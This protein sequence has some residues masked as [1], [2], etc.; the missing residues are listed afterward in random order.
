MGYRT[1]SQN[2]TSTKTTESTAL[3]VLANTGGNGYIISGANTSLAG[4]GL[5][6][7]T[8][9]VNTP[10]TLIPIA[11]GGLVSSPVITNIQFLSSAGSILAATNAASTLGGNILI[12]GTNFV[13]NVQVWVNNTTPATTT[14]ISSTQL[15]ATLPANA[16]GIASIIVASAPTPPAVTANIQFYPAPIW[17]NSNVNLYF[18][19]NNTVSNIPL[20]V[21]TLTGDTISFANTVLPTGLTVQPNVTNFGNGTYQSYI[22]GT[23][24]GYPSGYSNVSF[25][26]TAINSRLESTTQQFTSNIS[27]PIPV[28]SSANTFTFTQNGTAITTRITASISDCVPLT[29]TVTKGFLPTG[30]SLNTAGYITGTITCYVGGYNCVPFSITASDVE[31]QSTTQTYKANVSVGYTNINY[32]IVGGGGAGGGWASPGPQQGGSG[33]GGGG[34]A[35][36]TTSVSIGCSFTVSVGG[37]GATSPSAGCGSGGSGSSVFGASAGGGGGGGYETAASSGYPTSFG[38]C[39]SMTLGM[40]GGGG[41]GG[42]GTKGT[43]GRGQNPAAGFGFAGGNGGSALYVPYTGTSYAGGGAG[44]SGTSNPSGGI[45]FPGIR[46]CSGGGSAGVGG[47]GATHYGAPG[48][49]GG[50]Y[51]SGPGAALAATG[52]GKG[53]VSII[54]S[55]PAQ[56]ATGG[57]GVSGGPRYTHT[58]NNTGTFRVVG[59]V[60]SIPVWCGPVSTLYFT[61]NVASTQKI[62]SATLGATAITYSNTTAMP[63][64]LTLNN[65]GY[66]SGTVTGYGNTY[67][68]VPFTARATSS[69]GTYVSQ[70]FVA[71][72]YVPT[73]VTFLSALNNNYVL[74]LIQNGSSVTSRVTANI[75]FGTI[76]S[77][78]NTTAMPT[79]L[80]INTAGYISGAV[81]GYTSPSNYVSVPFTLQANSNVGT[82]AT[83]S[84]T[85]NVQVSYSI[86]YLLVGGGGSG[87]G[88][89]C[90]GGGGG[91]GGITTGTTTVLTSSPYTITVGGGGVACLVSSGGNGQKAGHAG[92]SSTAFGATAPGGC[93]AGIPTPGGPGAATGSGGT[94]GTGYAGGGGVTN[95]NGFNTGGAGGGAGGAASSSIGNSGYYVT[96]GGTG[97]VWSVNGGT[98]GGGGG[99][100]VTNPVYVYSSGGAGGGGVGAY[101]GVGGLSGAQAGTP[102]SGGGGGG[103][104]WAAYCFPVKTV[105]SDAGNGGSGTVII[106][107]TA[108][109]QYGIGGSVS[110]GPAGPVWYHTFT[111]TGTYQA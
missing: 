8:S 108:P 26:I 60:N 9:T 22:S 49:Y 92:T 76:V 110:G 11:Y 16:I 56:I 1:V 57:C 88:D 53:Q 25:A 21:S 75:G 66:I 17:Q 72:V 61:S 32:V 97:Y 63:F 42:A 30:L 19:M 64:G 70:I 31:G 28:F 86:N 111:G 96:Q 54:Y 41:A 100:G 107:Y 43:T 99:A 52:G 94:S 81:S 84:F 14:Y 18:T 23:I 33:G 80:T 29:Y 89:R 103:G 45:F 2:R 65:N 38:G 20:T 55:A 58:F 73:A 39:T 40:S 105:Y 95:S 59:A 82:S 35:T 69:T 68:C 98:Y 62:S 6:E 106:S 77:Y 93:G 74:S 34:V 36:G 10:Q 47:C 102:G 44:G 15:I 79:G 67:T 37:G 24:N 101:W 12:T 85:A 13:P 48:N 90:A 7:T 51:P 5:Y 109:A 71:N 46:G 78:A 3:T 83:Q 27:A 4:A 87:S 104:V 50:A 91:G